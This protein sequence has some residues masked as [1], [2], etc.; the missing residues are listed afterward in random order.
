MTFAWPMRQG[1]QRE[2]GVFPS[3]LKTNELTATHTEQ[4]HLFLSSHVCVCSNV[5]VA[6]CTANE[7]RLD[8]AAFG[9]TIP[10]T[11]RANI[12]F[13]EDKKM[14]GKSFASVASADFELELPSRFPE[15]FDELVRL[16]KTQAFTSKFGKLRIAATS[17]HI[18]E[19]HDM[20]CPDWLVPFMQVQN[21]KFSD[22]YGFDT[23]Q[24]QNGDCPVVVYA[25]HAVVYD[26]PDFGAFVEWTQK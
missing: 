13:G 11:F 23:T 22:F 24:K 6:I 1:E 20:G 10:K 25:I 16:S 18:R 17:E 21:P 2:P 9:F 14:D 15:Q 3:I 19:M 12:K 5:L 4:I 26:W 7:L 8:I